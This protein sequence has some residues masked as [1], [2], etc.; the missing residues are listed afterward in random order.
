M[1]KEIWRSL[2]AAARNAD[3][4]IQKLQKI[5]IKKLRK[6]FAQSIVLIMRIVETFVRMDPQGDKDGTTET[7]DRPKEAIYDEVNY[8]RRKSIK[9]SLN[10]DYRSLCSL[11]NRPELFW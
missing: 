2:S 10:A 4:D 3:L 8:V 9:P 7:V 5:D 1:N 6:L 11:Q